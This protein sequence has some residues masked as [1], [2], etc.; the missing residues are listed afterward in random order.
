VFRRNI[1]RDY[2]SGQIGIIII[3]IMVVLLTIG[4]SLA[5]RSTREVILSQQE[6]ESTRVFSA[7]EAGVEQALTADFTFAGESYAPGPTAIPN[8]N[9]TVDYTIQKM[10]VLDMRL[11]EGQAARVQLTD[12]ST[13]LPSS[14]AISW[15]RETDCST[16]TPASLIIAIFSVDSTGKTSVRYTAA[17]ACDHGDGVTVAGASGV[18][19]LFK[20]TTVNLQANDVYMRVK[21]VY[22]DTDV[23]VTASS[24]NF[25]VQYY[26]VH[27]SATNQLG[28]ENRVVEVKRSLPVAPSILDFVLV[29]GTSIQ[30]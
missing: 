29:S 28:N 9:A 19:G 27:S 3:L 24:G 8:T 23:Y 5:S 25:P 18:N 30:Q 12:S 6:E 26:S 2:Q 22:E 17:A 1:S 20:Q 10:H 15:S 7:A 4:L 13:P 16:Q 14:V 21:P 11:T